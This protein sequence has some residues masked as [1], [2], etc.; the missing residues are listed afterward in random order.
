MIARPIVTDRM[1]H[2]RAEPGDIVLEDLKSFR[3]ALAGDDLSP[4]LH[5]LSQVARFAAW[6]CACVENFFSWSRIQKLAGD[7][8]AG[9]L[10]VAMT[11]SESRCRQ[12]VELYKIRLAL[13]WSRIGIQLQKVF[14]V[15]L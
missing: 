7:N 6:R 15:D 1:N 5:Q 8:C 13:Q 3:I 4:V 12:S 11:R 14:R 2:C 9:I 10:N